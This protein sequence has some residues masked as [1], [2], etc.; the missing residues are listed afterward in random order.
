MATDEVN[1]LYNR[2][3]KEGDRFFI[4]VELD[5]P[6]HLFDRKDPSPIKGRDL[7]EDVV[8]Y[9]MHS[10]REIPH[11]HSISLKIY[12]REKTDD[13]KFS[14][15]QVSEAIR[16]FFFFEE[17]NKNMELRLK[18]KKGFKGLTIGL[19]FLFLCILF[20]FFAKEKSPNLFWLYVQEGLNVLG[21]VSMWYPINILLYEW[22]PIKEE[23]EVFH[24]AYNMQVEV[25][26]LR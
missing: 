5:N 19:C 6:K 11:R 16:T 12:F 1:P 9:I 7:N 17:Y 13:P 24:R 3:K 21:W 15:E 26:Y 18:F 23:I 22:W 4:E 8:T 2:Y 25:I 14:P 10:L 20:P